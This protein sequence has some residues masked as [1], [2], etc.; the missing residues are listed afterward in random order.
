[1][2]IQL[3]FYD[4]FHRFLLTYYSQV[5]THEDN[6][7][8]YRVVPINTN[9]QSKFITVDYLSLCDAANSHKLPVSLVGCCIDPIVVRIPPVKGE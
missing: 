7:N 4:L 5:E 2:N 8:S 1:M 3:F 6:S 9:N